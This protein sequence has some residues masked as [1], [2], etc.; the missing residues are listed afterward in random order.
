MS[1][2]MISNRTKNGACSGWHRLSKTRFFLSSCLLQ[3]GD[4]GTDGESYRPL[5]WA[6]G[7]EAAHPI[8]SGFF[9]PFGRGP[10]ACTSRDFAMIILQTVLAMLWPRLEVEAGGF[11]CKAHQL[12]SSALREVLESGAGRRAHL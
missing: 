12:G 2:R 10:R 4:Y 1:G 11:G 5:R 7:L 3:R 8:D 6:V 9:F